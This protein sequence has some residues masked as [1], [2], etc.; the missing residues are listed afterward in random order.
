MSHHLLTWPRAFVGA[1]VIGLTLLTYFQFPG[2][3]FLASDTQVY[4]PI[5]EHFRD[6]SLFRNE[7]VTQLPQFTFTVYD[8]VTLGLHRLTGLDLRAVL[9]A[10]QLVY[11]ALGILGV[12]LLATALGLSARM[13]LFVAATFALG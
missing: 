6:S 10:Q 7:L 11:R 8:E 5:L 2:H 1:S 13:A 12:Y 3:A 4:M 9:T